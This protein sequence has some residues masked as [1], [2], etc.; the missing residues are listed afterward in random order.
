MAD[1]QVVEHISEAE[2]IASITKD[3]F[4]EFVQEFWTCIPGIEPLVLNWHLEYLA[5]EL[6][7]VAERVFRGL[8]KE[9]DM[10]INVPPG[11]SKSTLCS[12]LYPAWIWTRMPNARILSASHTSELC[13][14]LANKSRMVINSDLYKACFPEIELRTDQDA[15]GYFINTLGGDRLTCT[16]AGK[17]PMGFH[18]HFLLPDDPIDPKKAV[19]EAELKTAR[20]FFTSVLPSRKVN[21]EVSVTILI[22]QRLHREDPTA[23]MLETGAKLGPSAVKHICLPGDVSWEIS[24]PELRS[25]YI[26]GVLSPTRLSRRSLKEKEITLGAYAYAGQ[27][28]QS[29]TPLGGGMFQETWFNN[30]VKAA[31]F[32]SKRVRYWD[33]ASSTMETGCYSVGVLMAKDAEGSYYVEDVV[34]GQWEPY[35][36]NQKILATAHRDRLKYARNE[37]IIYV[38]TEGGSTGID[39]NR[40]LASD[41]AGFVI[42]FDKPTGSKDVRAEPW[43]AQLAAGNVYIVDDGHATWDINAYI[44]EHQ[45][46]RP[47]PGKRLG[48]WKDQV[49][50][51]CLI[52][53]TMIKT[54]LG[55]KPIECIQAGEFVLTRVGYKEVE[56]AGKT[57]EVDTV[58]SVLFSNGSIVSGTPEHL[59]WTENRGWIELGLLKGSDHVLPGLEEEKWLPSMHCGCGLVG[60]RANT[61]AS[62]GVRSQLPSKSIITGESRSLFMDIRTVKRV[63]KSLSSMGSSTTGDQGLPTSEDLVRLCIRLFG[64][65]TTDLFPLAM[66]S[67]IRMGTQS[68]T[69]LKILNALLRRNMQQG[70]QERAGSQA[71]KNTCNE[72]VSWLLNG[73][74][75]KRVYSGIERTGRR[76]SKSE[77]LVSLFVTIVERRLRPNALEPGMGLDSVLPVVW[78]RTQEQKENTSD[79]RKSAQFATKPLWERRIRPA[80]PIPVVG[81]GGGK[82]SVYDLK[83]RDGHE[84][85]ANGILVH[86]SGAFNLLAGAKSLMGMKTVSLTYD[87]K[88]PFKKIVICRESD[89][90]SAIIEGRTL[91]ICIRDPSVEEVMCTDSRNSDSETQVPRSGDTSFS[92]EVMA[93][94]TAHSQDGG[95]VLLANVSLTYADIEPSDYQEHWNEIIPPYNKKPQDLILTRELGKKLWSV[96]AKHRD[97]DWEVLVIVHTGSPETD[98]RP[99]STAYAIA[100]SLHLPRDAA[101]FHMQDPEGAHDGVKAPSE[102]IYQVIRDARHMVI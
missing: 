36:R 54:N 44:S 17:S 52:A 89:L 28:G 85:F 13:L 100:D 45:H 21:N 20:E 48:R 72:L 95:P 7:K 47:E 18:G 25:R 8:P 76:R 77:K 29:P 74:N 11:T 62:V 33:R 55:L 30:R 83:V 51:S 5:E 27:Y 66:I 9:H 38:E 24:P 80:V 92:G 60:N 50:A 59:V 93:V 35:Q 99:L 56:W 43:S 87:K 32:K 97:P 90:G 79:L 10:V 34:R 70:I 86:N 22:M 1:P 6:Q 73:I 49:D 64:S 42:K 98:K 68:T 40:K 16:V 65:S 78:T 58:V 67:T 75:R 12:I 39:A 96:V 41:L 94:L 81:K 23:V 26:D 2:L 31:P 101:V 71:R 69:T 82:I 61:F 57:G 84:F 15:K 46:F 53:G 88:T 19:S 102:F 4:F 37:P 14:D 91:L 3:S 63:Q